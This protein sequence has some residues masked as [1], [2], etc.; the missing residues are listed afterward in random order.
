MCCKVMSCAS[1]Y[2]DIEKDHVDDRELQNT[3]AGMC[4]PDGFCKRD[5]LLRHALASDFVTHLTI[6]LAIC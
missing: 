4:G 3:T 5:Q 6:F 1:H 2:P